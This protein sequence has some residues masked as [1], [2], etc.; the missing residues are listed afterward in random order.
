MADWLKYLICFVA[1]YLAGNLQTAVFLSKYKLKDDVRKYGSGSAGS[2]NMLRVFG[3]KNGAITFA[4]DFL[5]GIFAILVGRWI[6]GEIGSYI[7]GIAAILGHDFPL[8]FGFKGGK[9][10]ATTIGLCIVLNPLA[11]LIAACI[12][13]PVIYFT[14]I[15]S[16]GSLLGIGL[17]AA[18]S[19]AADLT[20]TYLCIFY[21][22]AYLLIILRHLEN[23]G[24][25]IKGTESK[26]INRKK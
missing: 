25:L 20:N 23:I 17:I 6:G 11:V 2:T 15:V 19:V 9:G 3:L 22:A 7:C 5:K 12:A 14:G 26:T 18:I 10:V 16:I 24:R 4:G 13:L 21:A 8:F 1:G